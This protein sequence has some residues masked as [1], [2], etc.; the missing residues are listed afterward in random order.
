MKLKEVKMF[1]IS[2]DFEIKNDYYKRRIKYTY[3]EGKMKK[4]LNKRIIAVLLSVLLVLPLLPT[5]EIVVLATTVAE[6]VQEAKVT[7]NKASEGLAFVSNGDGTCS[8]SGIGT[9]TDTDVIIPSV[10]PAGSKVTHIAAQA[11]DSNDYITS[12]NI[13][14]GVISIEERAFKDCVALKNVSIPEGVTYIGPEAFIRCVR[15][16]EISIPDSVTM[17]DEAAFM[18]CHGLENVKLSDS[19]MNISYCL[20]L[21]CYRLKSIDIPEKITYIDDLAFCNCGLEIIKIPDSVTAIGDSAFSDCKYLTT[22]TLPH[23]MKYIADSLFEG[24]YSLNS[25]ELPENIVS[26]GSR[27]FNACG[28]E[29][30]YVHSGVTKIGKYAFYNCNY[31]DNL[32]I[33]NPVCEIADDA[34]E[35]ET[36]ICGY[37]NSTAYQ[38]ARNNGNPFSHIG[39]DY[40]LAFDSNGDGTCSVLGSIFVDQVVLIPTLSPDRER[41]TSIGQ[42]SNKSNITS[43]FIPESITYI[44]PLSRLSS[45][46]IKNITVSDNNAVYHSSGNCIIETMS[47]TLV[48][49][50]SN[51]VI[52]DDGSVT[53]IGDLAFVTCHG[54]TE[55]SIPGTV[56]EIG[57]EAFC[58][59]N[60]LTAIHFSDRSTDLFI[61]QAAFCNCEGLESIVIPSFVNMDTSAFSGCSNLKSIEIE[62]GVL[63]IWDMAFYACYSLESVVIPESVMYIGSGAFVKDDLQE[64]IEFDKNLNITIL[65]PKCKLDRYF[66]DKKAT[67]YGYVGSTAEEYAQ[68]YGNPFVALPTTTQETLYITEGD[69]DLYYQTR[70]GVNGTTDYRIIVV[71]KKE[72]MNTLES[73]AIK[74]YFTNESVS[75]ELN[76]DIIN[77]YTTIEALDS[78]GNTTIYSATDEAVIM[79]VV[80]KGVPAGFKLV[81]DSAVFMPVVE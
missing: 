66:V 64:N 18:D 23:N 11:F 52:P 72:Y 33:Y 16:L 44:D 70:E 55:I 37:D 47:K 76:F 27:A 3:L 74:A 31:M 22:V 2:Q 8:V 81:E 71:A 80:V 26:I 30:F 40:G 34:I 59:C 14:E 21:N 10:S 67:I 51:S 39:N 79:G 19:I 17:I 60:N 45:C 49:G 53:S 63:D 78:K 1:F 65:N 36:I 73:A 35:D 46:G 28:F 68:E 57:V 20:F 24:C 13:P 4:Y 48:V 25:I 58:Y 15:L 5:T 56:T 32:V 6:A 38:Y 61:S 54:L 42:F 77:A 75:K 62:D 69:Y 9:C 41:V 12:V 50:C 29:N 43:I 7:E